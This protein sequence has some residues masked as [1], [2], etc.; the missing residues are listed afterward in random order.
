MEY[1]DLALEISE[2]CN[3]HK[4][5]IDN[6]YRQTINNF[7]VGIPTLTTLDST[8]TCMDYQTYSISLLI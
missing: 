4:N 1:Q 8:P 6:N 3:K 2:I 5:Q 7:S